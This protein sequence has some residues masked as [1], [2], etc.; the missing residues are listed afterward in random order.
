M[1][2]IIRPPLRQPP[3]QI[4]P[5][6]PH[7]RPKPAKPEPTKPPLQYK[8][9]L[10]Q[11]TCEALIEALAKDLPANVLQEM[12]LKMD[13]EVRGMGGG[14]STGDSDAGSGDQSQVGNKNLV[15]IAVE[16]EA[17]ILTKASSE[18]QRGTD[19]NSLLKE[20]DR[21]AYK[22]L[23]QQVIEKVKE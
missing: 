19:A 16:L 9:A 11:T 21:V 7:Q 17:L 8:D 18:T 10:R 1:K 4:R 5:P 12:C 6:L 13:A 15:E 14:G 20:Q 2:P 23:A 22:A 3:S